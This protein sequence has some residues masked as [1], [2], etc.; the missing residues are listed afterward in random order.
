MGEQVGVELA[1]ARSPEIINRIGYIRQCRP[2]PTDYSSD[3]PLA[4]SRA[5]GGGGYHQVLASIMRLIAHVC[6]P[7]QMDIAGA[8]A[9]PTPTYRARSITRHARSKIGTAML[10]CNPE[11]TG[12]ADYIRRPDRFES[13][14]TKYRA[15]VAVDRAQQIREWTS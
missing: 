3:C 9:R 1:A 8:D 12:V 10:G 13:Q 7:L 2:Q 15:H 11:M 4:V 6:I 5:S 14:V